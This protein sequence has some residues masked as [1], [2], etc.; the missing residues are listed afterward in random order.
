MGV[1]SRSDE[2]T[3]A[4]SKRENNQRVFIMNELLNAPLNEIK[5]L[6]EEGMILWRSS[7]EFLLSI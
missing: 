1:S 6:D 2:E 3:K 5:S 4:L 7:F